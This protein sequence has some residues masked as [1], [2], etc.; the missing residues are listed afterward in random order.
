LS[1][2]PPAWDL[3][4]VGRTIA[5]TARRLGVEE[6]TVIG[7]CSGALMA[8]VATT[9]GRLSPQRL[10][11]IDPFAYFPWYFRVFT[12]GEFGRRAYYSTFASSIGRRITDRSLSARR[13][14]ET[15]LTSSFE[16]I[17]HGT[18]LEYLR[19]LTTIESPSMFSGLRMPIDIV[20]GSRTFG[21]I[22]RSVPIWKHVWPQAVAHTLEGVGHLPIE[23]APAEIGRI[24]FERSAQRAPVTVD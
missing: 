8:I 19:L 7:N 3:E 1:P 16:H 12:L 10:V 23:E 9:V 14:P 17:D 22:K 24:L 11:L 15:S 2:Q 20:V 13:S 5:R 18:S 21:A 4:S 6:A